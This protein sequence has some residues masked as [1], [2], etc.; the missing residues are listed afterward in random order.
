MFVKLCSYHQRLEYYIES[1]FSLSLMPNGPLNAN[2]FLK[3]LRSFGSWKAEAKNALINDLFTVKANNG[4]DTVMMDTL[5]R[6]F[7]F[8]CSQV[9]QTSGPDIFGLI[10]SL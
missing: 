7:T 5:S 10:Q 1:R 4:N 6:V 8:A 3:S 2:T 9:G